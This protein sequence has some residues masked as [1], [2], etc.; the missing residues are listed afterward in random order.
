[1]IF[2]Y[3]KETITGIMG[4]ADEEILLESHLLDELDADS[5]DISQIVLELENHYKIDLEDDAIAEWKTIADV[6]NHIE[7]RV[8]K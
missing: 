4:I 8:N 2:A 7:N 1:M 5:L 3:I 6:V